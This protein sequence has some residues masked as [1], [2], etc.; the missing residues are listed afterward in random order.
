MA[1]KTVARTDRVVAA[2]VSCAL[3]VAA[4][5]AIVGCGEKKSETGETRVSV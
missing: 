2:L 5:T 4:A 1:V 3:C